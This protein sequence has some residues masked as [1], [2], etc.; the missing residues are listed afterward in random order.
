MQ[1]LGIELVEVGPGTCVLEV[2]A[3]GERLLAWLPATTS[4]VVAERQAR[5]R[6]IKPGR[7]LTVATAEA[8]CRRAGALTLCA[9]LLPSLIC[10]PANPEAPRAEIRP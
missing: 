7:T 9:V 2:A 5:G 3:E 6:V 1:A 10:I 8:F 4:V